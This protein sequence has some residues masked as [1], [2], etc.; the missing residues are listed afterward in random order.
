M[1][2]L[3]DFHCFDGLMQQLQNTE[4]IYYLYILEFIVGFLLIIHSEDF[5]YDF[6]LFKLIS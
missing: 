2:F 4:N 3:D 1:F 5:M 6:P